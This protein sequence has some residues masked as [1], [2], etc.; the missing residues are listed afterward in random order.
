MQAGTIQLIKESVDLGVNYILT[1]PN[2]IVFAPDGSQKTVVPVVS[3]DVAVSSNPHNFTARYTPTM[4]GLHQAIFQFLVGSETL[5]STVNFWITWQDIYPLL[6]T[7]LGVNKV[8]LPDILID[9][10]FT[11]IYQWLFTL[12]GDTLPTY[13]QFNADYQLRFDTGMLY[14][15]AS[16]LRPT[17]G[18]TASAGNITLFK[19]GTTTVEYSDR[20]PKR[21]TSIEDI[22]WDQGID[23]LQTISTEIQ[24]A[25]NNDRPGD[26]I[27]TR[28]VEGLPLGNNH[29]LS[30]GNIG[31][32]IGVGGG[33][34]YSIDQYL[35]RRRSRCTP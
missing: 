30:N 26:M 8:Q 23:Y 4:G 35:T 17:I 3:P 31:W 27:M 21:R 25:I 5:Y 11:T 13:Y 14:L 10:E 16:R 6:R 32:Q 19:K 34:V 33:T 20:D 29:P 9:L 2:T 12:T 7:K 1:N 22:W 24:L 15:L 28:T 18:G